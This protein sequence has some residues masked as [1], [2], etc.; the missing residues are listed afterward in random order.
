MPWHVTFPVLQIDTLPETNTSPLKIDHPKKK[1]ILKLAPFSGQLFIFREPKWHFWFPGFYPPLFLPL[2][3]TSNSHIPKKIT[4]SPERFMSPVEASQ[5]LR[6]FRS[7]G[8]STSPVSWSEKPSKCLVRR[9]PLKSQ[10]EMGKIC[11]P[12]AVFFEGLVIVT[13]WWL[14]CFFVETCFLGDWNFERL[15]Y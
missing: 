3:T 11:F 2:A 14:E 13:V 5:R 8:H 9:G 15:E 1:I 12:E 10:G 4:D 6:W 7:L